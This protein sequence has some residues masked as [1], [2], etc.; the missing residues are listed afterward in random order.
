MRARYLKEIKLGIGLAMRAVGMAM[1]PRGIKLCFAG[2]LGEILR[3]V[4]FRG[5]LSMY[6][7]TG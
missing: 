6:Q 5:V 7:Y 3:I 2:S 4:S 1:I